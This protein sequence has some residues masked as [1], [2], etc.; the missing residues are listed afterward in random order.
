MLLVK[1]NGTACGHKAPSYLG[2]TALCQL[3]VNI[4]GTARTNQQMKVITSQPEE[5]QA[6]QDLRRLARSSPKGF[7]FFS[8][9]TW[10]I[11]E[12]KF[13]HFDHSHT[14]ITDKA[15]TFTSEVLQEWYRE[16]SSTHFNGAK[17]N[18]HFF[19]SLEPKISLWACKRAVSVPSA[20][21]YVDCIVSRRFFSFTCSRLLLV[22]ALQL[23]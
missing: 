12:Q 11:L 6:L 5:K 17:K 1:L 8:S 9:Q 21:L 10:D 3:Q 7:R 23:S 16:R 20:C 14:M 15:L 18:T 4:D 22:T 13:E 2:L 19:L